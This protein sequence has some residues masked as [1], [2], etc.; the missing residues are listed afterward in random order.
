VTDAKQ[1]A[2]ALVADARTEMLEFLCAAVRTP[3]IT[4]DEE[5]MSLLIEEWLA[6]NEFEFES[7]N[8]E[9]RSTD[10]GGGPRRNLVATVRSPRPTFPPL[11]INAHVDTV[12]PGNA[13]DWVHPPFAGVRANGKI[14]GRG[15]C[16]DKGPLV[17][18]LFALRAIKDVGTDLPHDIEFQC[19]VGEETGGAGTRAVLARGDKP[20]AAIVLEA[21]ECAV[22]AAS[23][24]CM[25]FDIRVTGKAAHTAVPW[26]GVSAY[27]K[28]M[29]V[30]AGLRTFASERNERSRHPLFDHFPES[31]P[32][33][34][35]TSSAGEWRSMV[36]ERAVLSGRIGLL[37]GQKF[38]DVAE[39]LTEAVARIAAGDPWLRDV[40]PEVTW[41]GMEFPAWETETDHPVVA[42]LI[43][44]AQ[45]V[46]GSPRVGAVTYGSDAGHF[47]QRGPRWRSSVPG[48]PA[49]PHGE[50][51]RRRGRRR[52]G[53]NDARAGA[54]ELRA[55]G[56]RQK[57]MTQL[58]W[59]APSFVSSGMSGSQ[60]RSEAAA[61][62]T[63]DRPGLRTPQRTATPRSAIRRRW[64]PD[65]REGYVS[66]ERAR[67][68]Y[69]HVVTPR[70]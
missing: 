34:I 10:G 57:R 53:S 30:Y 46:S 31:A 45:A 29:T 56:R 11:V 4:G 52:G 70:S 25:H 13:S 16:D 54:P 37:P 22:I 48:H 59:T 24:G 47:A 2:A 49:R 19:V 12:V 35:G 17:A 32:L 21:T 7:Q 18:G 58:S 26:T 8:V 9:E 50:R 63:H 65:L 33:A 6:A 23:G 69:P 1:R 5:P 20:G 28:A 66:E 44:A 15:A 42:S 55:P 27:E 67:I 68:D 62:A 64:R 40:R 3:S 38:S 60:I 61:A 39:E 41:P 36:P 43:E 51:A 14:W